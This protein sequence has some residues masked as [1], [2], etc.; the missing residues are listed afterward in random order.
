MPTIGIVGGGQLGRMLGLAGIPLGFRFRFLEPAHA[1]P[2][3]EVGRVVRGAYA[4]AGALRRF[5]RGLSLVTYEFENVPAEATHFLGETLGLPVL[6]SPRALAVAQDRLL[7]KETFRALGIPT[8]PYR[9]V[10][11]REELESA[12]EELGFPAVLKTRRMGYDGKGQAVLRG[13]EEVGRSW[14]RLGG[15]PLILEGFVPFLRELSVLA[16]RGRGGETAFYPLVENHHE[17]GILTLSRVPASPGGGERQREGE[18][19]ARKLLD[20]LGYV[21]VLAIELFETAEGLVANELAP[22][23]HNS[24][25]W[26]QDGAVTSQFEN[27]LRAV[28]GLPLGETSAWGPAGMVN[29]IGT[30]PPLKELLAIEGARPHLYGKEPRPGRKLGHVNLLGD[31]EEELSARV[32]RV[33]ALIRN[34]AATHSSQRP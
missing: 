8:P 31:S 6:P 7:E 30:T 12:L 2:A 27:H 4:D 3:G 23:V 28:A 26:T 22:R 14:E 15:V 21:G 24:G 32:A 11:H 29:L 25:H 10:D 16:V 20:H 1:P 17:E 9:A 5:S 13:A 34:Q 18:A 33:Q 19:I